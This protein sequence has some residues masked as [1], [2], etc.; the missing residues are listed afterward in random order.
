MS[1]R[2]QDLWDLRN[3]KQTSHKKKH[4][5]IVIKQETKRK[6]NL[7]KENQKYQTKENAWKTD[8][9]D[10]M[11]W[12][13]DLWI[14]LEQLSFNQISEKAVDRLQISGKKS[15]SKQGK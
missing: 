8:L 9:K 2:I 1:F 13:I 6:P 7:Q 5:L 12:C 4:T 14:S 10:Q 15:D 3:R 11:E